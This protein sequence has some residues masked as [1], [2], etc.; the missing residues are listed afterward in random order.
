[1]R[2]RLGLLQDATAIDRQ[3]AREA[4][5]VKAKQ[6]IADIPTVKTEAQT[7]VDAEKDHEKGHEKSKTTA[8][9]R[10]RPLSEAKAI[11]S[12][13]NFISEGFLFS[14]GLGLIIFEGFR[15]R[16]K[17]ASRRSDVQ[18][19]LKELD[20]RDAAKTSRIESLQMELVELRRGILSTAGFEKEQKTQSA[21]T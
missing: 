9:P 11:D 4:A 12:G 16:R 21:L 6:A 13:A 10:I 20:D 3:I 17:E 2:L 7:K 5:E 18:D 15:S 14:V 1:M 19:K 8:K